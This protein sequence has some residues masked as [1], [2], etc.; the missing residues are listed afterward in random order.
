M[1]F[2]VHYGQLQGILRFINL[3]YYNKLFNDYIHIYASS[4]FPNEGNK[5][6]HPNSIVDYVN[7]NLH[8]ASYDLP[9]SSIT[10][11]FLQNR[12]SISHYTFQNR[13]G[14]DNLPV[15]WK[16]EGS[17]DNETWI[18][19]H[20]KENSNDLLSSGAK[21][22]YKVYV[23]GLFSFFKLTQTGPNR[24]GQSIFH[25]ERVEFYGEFC[26]FEDKRCFLPIALPCT[27]EIK[28]F[29]HSFHFLII[30]LVF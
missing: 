18:L 24:N 9:N 8:W 11:H 4:S 6:N 14:T 21:R 20:S 12:I 15:S 27:K 28:N 30:T 29:I 25:V 10:V 1:F 22:T 17:N 13:E 26:T 7:T 5:W 23:N 16:L 2:P 19:L 3:N